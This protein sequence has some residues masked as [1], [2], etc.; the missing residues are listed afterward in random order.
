MPGLS[1]KEYFKL[2]MGIKI[3]KLSLYQK[4]HAIIFPE[5][6]KFQTELIMVSHKSGFSFFLNYDNIKLLPIQV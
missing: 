4:S 5:K 3:D 1:K 2:S 6:S